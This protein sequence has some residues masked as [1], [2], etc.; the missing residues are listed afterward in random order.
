M[1][2]LDSRVCMAG[3]SPGFV[4]G[5]PNTAQWTVRGDHN[6]GGTIDSVT[7]LTRDKNSMFYTEAAT[8]AP[9]N[10]VHVH[11]CLPGSGRLPGTL[12]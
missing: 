8:M 12:H 3:K 5:G 1:A 6:F 2:G 7:A 9:L 4:L 10:V 11:G